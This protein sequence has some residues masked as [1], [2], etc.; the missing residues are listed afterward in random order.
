MSVVETDQQL[1]AIQRLAAQFITE[2]EGRGFRRAQIA[3]VMT[4]LGENLAAACN[5]PDALALVIEAALQ[6]MDSS[7]KPGNGATSHA[8]DAAAAALRPARLA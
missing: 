3:N 1:A 5:D 8:S 4:G 6:E 7:R 2:L